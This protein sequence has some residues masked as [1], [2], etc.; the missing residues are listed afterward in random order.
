MAFCVPL[1]Q[2]S[3]R[4]RSML[5]GTAAR[6]ATVS[7]IRSAPSSSATLRKLSMSVITPEDVSP[8]AKPT[9]LIFLPLPAPAHVFGID[10]L[11]V[12]RFDFGDFRRRVPGDDGHA[13]GKSAVDGDD[14]F[15]ALFES[16]DDRG[17]DAAGARSRERHGDAIFGLKDLAQQDL[18][19]V[20]AAA[21]P[22][23][24]VAN[25]RRG[26]GAVDARVHRGRTRGKHQPVGGIEFADRCE[27]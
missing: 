4:W 27:S 3:M 20:H 16:V 8:C 6:D 15:V 17:F 22:G 5:M 13:I 25:Q 12:G 18:D 24:N 26:Q 1:K 9:I 21:E 19:V 23:V 14:G 2:M 7:T 11:A 10:G